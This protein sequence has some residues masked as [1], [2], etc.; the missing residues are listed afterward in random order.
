MVSTFRGLRAVFSEHPQATS[1]TVLA[2]A[3][4]V[5]AMAATP[6]VAQLLRTDEA[7]HRDY[8][9]GVPDAPSDGWVQSSGGRLYDNWAGTLGFDAPEGTHPAYPAAGSQSGPDTWR[10]K[11]CH[12]WDYKGADGKYGG[13]SHFSG[14]V[15]LRDQVAADPGAIVAILRDAT[16]RY[17]EAMIPPDAAERLAG[18]G[19]LAGLASPAGGLAGGLHGPE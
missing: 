2:A 10:C 7:Y 5:A 13:G 18:V 15:G 1:F 9:Y 4:A 19:G 3:L 14:I 6:S 11:E 12:G 8:I 17:T 16:H